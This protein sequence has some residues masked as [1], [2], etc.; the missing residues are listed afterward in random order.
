MF[1]AQ[2]ITPHLVAFATF[3][4]ND[5]TTVGPRKRGR[6]TSTTVRGD[7]PDHTTWDDGI[8]RALTF[9]K[10]RDK[11]PTLDMSISAIQKKKAAKRPR[12]QQRF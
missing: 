10:K 8:L 1:R 7:M 12:E 3:I 5:I 6:G 9:M 2:D 4:A 11:C